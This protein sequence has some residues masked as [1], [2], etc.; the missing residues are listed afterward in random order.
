[1]DLRG[2]CDLTP[3]TSCTHYPQESTL[4]LT[5]NQLNGHGALEDAALKSLFL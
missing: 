5:E 2:V 1:M 4:G 3:V